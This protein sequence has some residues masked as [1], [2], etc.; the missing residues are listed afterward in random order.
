MMQDRFGH[1]LN[2]GD[3]VLWCAVHEGVVSAFVGNV[4]EI[5]E[6]RHDGIEPLIAVSWSYRTPPPGSNVSG[7]SETYLR[8]YDKYKA[9]KFIAK[10]GTPDHL[11]LILRLA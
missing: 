5:V 6:E 8:S 2:I 10:V 11:V 4:G 1:E 7:A 9:N 3:L